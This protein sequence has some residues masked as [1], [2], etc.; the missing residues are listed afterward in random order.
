[1]QTSEQRAVRRNRSGAIAANRTAPLDEADLEARIVTAD[2]V[3]IM[4]VGRHLEKVRRVL[5][6][7]G[8]LDNAIYVERA[9]LDD[10]KVM[11]L[12]NLDG[13]RAP[14]FSMILARRA[15]AVDA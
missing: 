8:R 10:E 7:L 15:E 11:P 4:K 6:K 5:A 1:M 3:A 13:D 9:T 12:M 2:A 14:Y